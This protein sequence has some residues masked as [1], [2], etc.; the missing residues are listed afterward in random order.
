[1]KTIN[2]VIIDDEISALKGLELKIRKLVPEIDILKTFSK[3]ENAV[4]WLHKNNP[5][6]VFLDIEMPRLNGFELLSELSEIPFQVIFVTAYSEYALQALK[7][8][9]V[10][11]ILKPVENT[12]LISAIDKAVTIIRNKDIEATQLNLIKLLHETLSNTNKLV[13]PTSVGL[14]FI[15]MDEILH[16]EGDEGYTRIHLEETPSILSSYSLGRFEKML[17]TVFF[18]CHKSHIIN[19]EKVRSFENEGY[20]C[21][22]NGDRVPISKPNRKIFLNL[23]K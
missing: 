23:F 12:E 19:L 9:A 13:V 3:P 7:H 20:I 16:L 22:E 2:A 18:K 4:E 10:D 1:M 15:P 6:L 21:L 11:Y 17:T 8:S 14:S 5:D